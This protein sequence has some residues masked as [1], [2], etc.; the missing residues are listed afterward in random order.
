M[1]GPKV[2]LIGAGSRGR[3]IYSAYALETSKIDIVA[4]AE[5][6]DQ[7]RNS[8]AEKLKISSDRRFK[9]WKDLLSVGKIADGVI[10]ATMDNLHV[11]PAIEFMKAGYDILLEKPIDRTLDGAIKVYLYSR[12]YKK[13]VMVAHVLRYTKFFRKIRE[14]VSNGIVGDLIGIE[15]KENVGY[16]HMAHSFVRG[17]WRSREE[18]AP[19]ILTKS[20]HDMDIIYWIIGKKCSKIS[21]FGNLMHF[22]KE[23]M[24]AGAAERCLDCKVED[25]CP[26]SALKLYLN[27]STGWPQN[28]ISDD[29]S[30][31]G[32]LKALREGPYGRCVYNCDNDV[33]DHQVVSMDFE[34]INVNFTMQAFTFEMDRRIRIFGSKGEIQGHF[35]KNEIDVLLFGKE[36]E[37]IQIESGYIDTLGHSGGDF[38]MLDEFVKMLG[39]SRYESISTSIGDSLESHLMAWAAEESR[40]KNI[41]IDMDIYRSENIDRVEKSLE[42]S[43]E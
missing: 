28:V 33:V 7:R 35:G 37:K 40:L 43:N 41:V 2:V 27:S 20:C 23:K 36:R 38:Y 26:Y 5:P 22:R 39:D 31:E 29:L 42:K 9:D 25:E 11:E 1:A 24:P 30:Y 3:D 4:L 10:I 12:K 18:T 16:W 14:L 21:S 8:L 13:R 34:G 6:N 15:H 17:N 19:M 32:R